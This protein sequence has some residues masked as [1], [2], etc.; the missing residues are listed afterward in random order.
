M[1]PKTATATHYR[2]SNRYPDLVRNGMPWYALCIALHTA[3]HRAR[4]RALAN[5][6]PLCG[7]RGK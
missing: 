3:M 7:K 2:Y 5:S 4:R 1:G 6:G